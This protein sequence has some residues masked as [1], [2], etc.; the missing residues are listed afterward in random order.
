M[1]IQRFH[2]NT[3]M[4]QVVIHNDTIYLSGQVDLIDPAP[5]VGEQTA[6]VLSRIDEFLREAGSS[7]AFVL[8]ATIW[9][10]DIEFF[11]EMN[12]VWDQWLPVGCAPARATVRADL[13]FESLLVEISVIA[14]VSPGNV[15][16]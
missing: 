5:T 12:R 1:S 15:R 11:G 2:S 3:H 13:A 6:R 14:A 4:S 7:K 16:I 10:A 8:S 9:L